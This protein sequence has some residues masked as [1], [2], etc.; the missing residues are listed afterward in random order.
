MK[1][2][3]L[4]EFRPKQLKAYRVPENLKAEVNSQ[5]N[6]LLNRGFIKPSKSPMAS[7]VVCVCKG[8]DGK[9]GVRLAVNCQYLNKYT[10]PDVLPLPDVSQVIQKVGAY[11][12]ISLF[13]ATSGY[14]QCPIRPQDQWLS[15]F[16]CDD[17]LYEWTSVLFGMRSSGCTF[18]RAVKEIIEPVKKL[19]KL[20][21]TT[22]L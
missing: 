14:H 16:V 21:S 9:G 7:P 13:D 11:R 19:Q 10:V 18:V 6:T 2:L 22:W 5:I 12:Y 15:A 17:G 20:M 8:K 1:S 4:A 3:L